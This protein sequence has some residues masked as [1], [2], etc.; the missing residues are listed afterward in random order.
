MRAHSLRA[1][2]FAAIG[3]FVAL[4]V[5]ITLGLGLVLTRRAVQD[6]TLKD[7][8][9]QAALIVGQERSALSPLTNFP[10]FAPTSRASTSATCSIPAGSRS[11]RAGGS[12]P[13]RRRQDR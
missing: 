2:L 6:A 5:A 12:R 1:R 9:H 8:A 13:A 4:A 10:S 11:P 7:L 3:V